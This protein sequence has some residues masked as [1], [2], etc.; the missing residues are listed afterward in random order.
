MKRHFGVMMMTTMTSTMT[1]TTTTRTMTW[2]DRRR[3]RRRRSFSFARSPAKCDGMKRQKS[4]PKATAGD[5]AARDDAWRERTHAYV[6]VYDVDQANE[7]L[8]TT[9]TRSGEV[10]TNAFVAFEDLA[11]ALRACV[12]VGEA[13]REQP[14]AE[15]TTTA[16]LDVLCRACAYDVEFIRRGEPFDVPLTIVDEGAIVVDYGKEME[17]ENWSLAALRALAPRVEERSIDRDDE[18]DALARERAALVEARFRAAR[19]II[20]ACRAPFASLSSAT[21]RAAESPKRIGRAYV[22]TF[23]ATVRDAAARLERAKK[24]DRE[25]N[26]NAREGESESDRS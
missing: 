1:S 18:S 26:A 12:K 10:A 25:T 3:R 5:D 17:R 2:R 9:S 4:A 22:A 16:R 7:A 6:L 24:I 8:Y 23:N 13:T 11:D 15:R 20:A 21:R 19:A 14:S